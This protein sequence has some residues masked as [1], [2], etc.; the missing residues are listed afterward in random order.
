MSPRTAASVLT[1]EGHCSQAINLTPPRCL[2]N[3]GSKWESNDFAFVVR[4]YAKENVTLK[5]PP[6]LPHIIRGAVWKGEREILLFPIWRHCLGNAS[7]WAPAPRPR[8]PSPRYHRIN[9]WIGRGQQGRRGPQGRTSVQNAPAT[10]HVAAP[11][12]VRN[13]LENHGWGVRGVPIW[14]TG[15]ISNNKTNIK[16]THPLLK[17]KLTNDSEKMLL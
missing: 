4:C 15:T 2:G 9:C 5:W 3:N 10:V 12:S 1:K 17:N 7:Q 16:Q 11:Q 6:S 14:V 8:S 13:Q